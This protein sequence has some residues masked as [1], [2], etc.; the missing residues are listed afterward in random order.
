MPRFPKA[1]LFDND[2]VLVD[3]EALY[4]RATRDVLATV[5]VRLDEAAYVELFLRQGIGAFHLAAERGVS[6]EGVLALRADRNRLYQEMIV[7]EEILIA[8]VLDVVRRLAE[9]FRLA[10]VTSAEPEP[11][12]S[13]HARTG[14]LPFFEVVITRVDTVR[15][16]P[17]PDPYLMALDRLGLPAAECLVIEDSER[18]LRAAKAA[19]LACWV[20]PAGLT[21]GGDF[22]AADAVLA[23]LDVAAALLLGAASDA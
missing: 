10:I 3:T 5:G 21:R 16:K 7:R 13:S 22:T 19:G 15:A 17:D 20:I 8:G 11:F 6:P 23:D 4:F 14:L 2:G 18:G 9:R 1:I 12:A